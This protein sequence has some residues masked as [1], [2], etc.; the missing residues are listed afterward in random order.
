MAVS[1]THLDVYKRQAVEGGRSAVPYERVARR[2]GVR[3]RVNVRR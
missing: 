3:A 1:Y 2:A